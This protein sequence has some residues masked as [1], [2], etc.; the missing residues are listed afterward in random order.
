MHPHQKENLREY[1]DKLRTEGYTVVNGHTPTLTSSTRA[2]APL[3]R[4]A[5]ATHTTR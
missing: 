5:K 4:G 3:K 1:I 2:D